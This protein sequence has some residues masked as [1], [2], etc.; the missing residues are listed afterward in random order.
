MNYINKI[1]YYT[2]NFYIKRQNSCLVLF[3]HRVND[4]DLD[5]QLLSISPKKFEDEVKYLKNNF[6]IISFSEMIQYLQNNELPKMSAVITFDD[7]YADNYY[8]AKEILSKYNAPATFFVTSGMIDSEREFWWDELENIFLID[9]EIYKPLEIFIDNVKYYWDIKNKYDAVVVYQNL[10]KLLHYTNKFQ[11]NK[12]MK[13]LFDWSGKKRIQ[14][15]THKT[16]TKEELKNLASEKLF[17]VGSHTVNHCCLA[18]E[19]DEEQYFEM[20]ESKKNLENIIGREITSISYPFGNITDINNKT[21]KIVKEIG[22]KSATA[23]INSLVFKNTNLYL[24]PKIL[25][26]NDNIDDLHNKIQSLK[27]PIDILDKI[28]QKVFRDK[29]KATF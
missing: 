23:I 28:N 12:T 18:F 2:K 21:I 19:S 6:N 27:N 15:F 11:I 9:F 7:G 3:Y 26:R 10:I 20:T 1:I 5:P 24:I 17:E 4:L 14:R 8:I 22:Y 29:L 13:Y 16:L 25:S